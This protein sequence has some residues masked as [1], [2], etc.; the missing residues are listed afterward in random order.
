MEW[1]NMDNST[2]AATKQE[3]KQVYLFEEGSTQMR[4]ILGGKGCELSEMTKMG[5]PVPSGFVITTQECLKYQKK[6]KMPSGV[7]AAM[8]EAMKHLESK[9]GRKFGDTEKPLLVSVRSGAPV[10]MPGMMDTILNLGLNDQTVVAFGKMTNERTA[11]DAY[12]RFV[13]MFGEVVLGIEKKKFDKIFDAIKEKYHRKL[14][15]ELTANELKEVVVGFKEIVKRETG[16]QFP[17]DPKQQLMMAVGA[18]F[19]SWNNPRAITYRNLY[20]IPH[21]MGTAVV[22]QTMVFGNS[23]SNSGTG[24]AFSRNPSTGEHKLYGEYLMN[25]QGEDVVAGIRTPN[26]IS[27]MEKEHPHIYKQFHEI[28][29][30]LEKHYRDMQDMEFTIDEGKLFML[31]T[32][33]GKRTAAAAV[34]AAV[35]MTEEGLITKEEAVMRVQPFQ[36]DQLL[37][38]Q[39]DPK[40]RVTSI[41]KGL[42]ASP[43][44]ASGK[45]VFTADDAAEIGKKEKVMLVAV[46]TTPDDIH[47]M[48][49]SQGIFTSRGGMT[50]HSAVVARGMGLPCVCGCEAAK[51]DVEK[52]IMQ[53]NG[54][55][56][57]EGDVVTID[58]TLGTI[59]EGEIPLVEPTLTGEFRKFLDWCDSLSRMYVRANADTPGGAKGA[60]EFGAKGIGLCRTERMF[61]DQDRLPIVQGMIMSNSLEER[62]KWL[63]KLLVFQKKD[64]YDILLAMDGLPVT[65]RLLDPPL[66]EF[67]PHIEELTNSIAELSHKKADERVIAEKERMLKKVREI[68]EFNPMLGHRGCRLGITYPEIYE[69]QVTAIFEAATQLKKEGKK[70]IVEV[71]VPLIGNVREFIILKDLIKAKAEEIIKKSGAPFEFTVGTMI[72]I[73]RAALTADEI[74]VEAEFFSFGTND[75]TQTALGFSRDDAEAKFLQLYLEKK[76]YD[77]NP[78]EV[79]D[80]GV[81]KLVDMAVKL[82]RKKRKDLKIGVCGETGGEPTSIEF[83]H[84]T[85]LNY[86]SCSRYRVPIARLACAQATLKEKASTAKKAKK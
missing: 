30:K 1:I 58:G 80:K 37:H 52:K 45:I 13:Q 43:G 7:E 49:A 38:R 34:K 39:I 28:S 12:R 51:I 25:A 10:S 67:L 68:T 4:P 32:R 57:K 74:A 78:F 81:G 36:I 44:A 55:I 14:D 71:M 82:G 2:A 62:K 8:M 54:K 26:P 27:H 19:G 77:T 46:E 85:G 35:D 63:D 11:Y 33:N 60:R 61:N 83:Y 24:V 21:N 86:V 75:L 29:Q 72:E 5:L 20:K 84:N 40:A 6:K 17:D 69:M 53:I 59:M 16:S 66:H 65:I 79:V 15:T 23:G 42:P 22:V 3:I 31:Q 70:P 47:G 41:A 76:I 9:L 18:V 64:F 48:I 50:C 73:P 56:F